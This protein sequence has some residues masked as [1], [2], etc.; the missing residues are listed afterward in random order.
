[1]PDSEQSS[2]GLPTSRAGVGLVSANSS[3][4][5]DQGAMASTSNSQSTTSS[6]AVVK[7]MVKY[8]ELVI[9]GYNGQLPQGKK[10]LWKCRLK[11]CL[12]GLTK[13]FGDNGN[14]HTVWKIQDLSV[15]KILRE[16]DFGECKKCHFCNIR[17]FDF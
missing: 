10:F 17:D 7:A 9:L 2:P 16:I 1:M 13:Y 6:A 11:S 8:G 15:A 14:T 3:G 4:N 12:N 5:G